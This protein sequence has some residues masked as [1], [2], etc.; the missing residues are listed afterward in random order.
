MSL[1]SYPKS[2]PSQSS[3]PSTTSILLPWESKWRNRTGSYYCGA[4][5]TLKANPPTWIWQGTSQRS[6]DKLTYDENKVT[7]KS[8]KNMVIFLMF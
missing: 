1:V 3:A 2:V 6:V 5:H 8:Q 4:V 7:M